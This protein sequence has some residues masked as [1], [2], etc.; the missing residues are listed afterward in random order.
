MPQ[1]T[2]N[3]M[4]YDYFASLFEYD[5]LTGVIT[6]RIARGSRAKAGSEAGCLKPKGYRQIGLERMGFYA[7]RVAWLLHYGSVNSTLVVDHINGIKDDNRIENLRLVTLQHNQFN[8]KAS[9]QWPL[10]VSFYNPTKKFRAAITIY[11]KKKHLGYF[12]TPELAEC[13]YLNAKEKLHAIN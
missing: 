7:H 13:A 11:Q 10:G 4:S 2:T 12:H 1:L 3:T 5:S 6:N 9:G 8:R